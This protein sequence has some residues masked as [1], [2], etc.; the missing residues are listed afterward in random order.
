MNSRLPIERRKELKK[1]YKDSLPKENHLSG[2]EALRE[3]C[4]IYLEDPVQDTQYRLIV[5]YSSKVSER[6]IEL[7][8][9]LEVIGKA[10][11][12]KL[13]Q[14]LVYAKNPFLTYITKDSDSYT[15]ALIPSKYSE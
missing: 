14:S 3:L 13:W 12:I 7:R 11:S 15:Y 10:G 2:I 6:L 1:L 9:R 4:D 8:A 5:R